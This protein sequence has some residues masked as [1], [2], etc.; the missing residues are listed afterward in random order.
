VTGPFRTAGDLLVRETESG[1]III[2]QRAT[3][4]PIVDFPTQPEHSYLI[5]VRNP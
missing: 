1:E 3:P 2:T 4:E 5:E